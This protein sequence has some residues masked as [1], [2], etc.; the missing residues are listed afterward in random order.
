MCVNIP[1]AYDSN[2]KM[3]HYQYLKSP[4]HALFMSLPPAPTKIS[5]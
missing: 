5:V 1:M 4:Y 2:F 3:E